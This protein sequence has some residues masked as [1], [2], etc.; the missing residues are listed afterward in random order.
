MMI[1]EITAKAGAYKAKKRLGRGRVGGRPGVVVGARPAG[2]HHDL[3]R[4]QADRRVDRRRAERA[5]HHKFA[6]AAREE[7]LRGVIHVGAAAAGAERVEVVAQVAD[8]P[9]RVGRA[10]LG[11]PAGDEPCDTRACRGLE[12]GDSARRYCDAISHCRPPPSWWASSPARV[13]V[14]V[15]V[16]ACRARSR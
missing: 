6:A 2:R 9:W 5:L 13:P 14:R 11:L 8:H 3:R 7:R 12:S 4:V 15:G 16:R 1:H 10:E